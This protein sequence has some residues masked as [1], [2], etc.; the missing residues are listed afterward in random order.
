[1]WSVLNCL[2]IL[3]E[4]KDAATSSTADS[5]LKNIFCFNFVLGIM[6]PNSV[7]ISI[8]Y[9][10]LLSTAVPAAAA[11]LPRAQP[12]VGAGRGGDQPVRGGDTLG[13]RVSVTMVAVLMLCEKYRF[14]LANLASVPTSLV[15]ISEIV[16][17]QTSRRFVSAVQHT[18][19]LLRQNCPACDRLVTGGQ[20]SQWVLGGTGSWVFVEV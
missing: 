19:T 10:H 17:L 8:V 12:E 18:I 20:P 15:P 2:D 14:D 13:C 4:D 6:V 3:S 16:K 1:M 7:L 11:H 9:L 5:L